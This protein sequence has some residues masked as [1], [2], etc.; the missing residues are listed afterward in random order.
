MS[1]TVMCRKYQTE[2]DGLNRPPF[3]G[4]KGQDIFETVS[5][6]AWQEWL[7]EQ[8]MLINEKHL[9][10]MDPQARAFLDEQ[11][12]RFLNNENYEKAEGYTP[13]AHDANK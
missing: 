1:R 13:V 3:P 12:D 7:H 8:T 2:L 10:V 4:P 9:N 6:K 11:R 5:K